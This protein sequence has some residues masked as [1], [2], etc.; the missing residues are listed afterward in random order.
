LPFVEVMMMLF[1][2]K[3]LDKFLSIVEGIRAW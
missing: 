2:K 1:K 3:F